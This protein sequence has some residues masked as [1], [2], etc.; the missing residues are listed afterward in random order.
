MKFPVQ[1]L[2]DLASAAAFI[3]GAGAMGAGAR[4]AFE[5]AVRADWP[6]VV[7]G[8]FFTLY[9]AALLCFHAWSERYHRRMLGVWPYHR[10]ERPRR[11]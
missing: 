2:F 5:G 1:L 7:F 10:P 4:I 3:L 6:Q 9:M 8:A 11:P